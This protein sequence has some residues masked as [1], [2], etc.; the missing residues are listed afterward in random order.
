[1]EATS[2]PTFKNFFHQLTQQLLQNHKKR[3]IIFVQRIN[4][5]IASCQAG[6]CSFSSMAKIFYQNFCQ[7]SFPPL[8]SNS[9][10][11]STTPSSKAN[12]FAPVFASN[13]NLGDQGVKPHHFPP[14]PLQNSLSPIKFSTRKVRQTFLQLDTSKSKCPDG[15][16]AIVLKTCAPE[17]APILNKLFQ[18]SNNLGTFPTSWKQAHVFPIPKK[19]DKSNPLNYRPIAI[20]SLISKTMETIIT[21]QLLTFL[22]TNNLL[23]D[24]QYGFRK[25]RS[26]GDLL[27]YAVHVWSSALE[28]SGE[29]RVISLSIS[30]RPL[31]AFG[32]GAFSLNCR[33]LASITLSLIGLVVSSLIVLMIL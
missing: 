25:A 6:S 27:A 8:K 14:P 32:T 29:S 1:M 24:H 17:L 7:S 11:S 10:S 2:N 16:T 20:T 31:I 5:K 13:S 22:E 30:P 4:N 23:S 26:T 15:I 12:L 21:K 19:G 18:L 3:Q 33:C 28:S 9:D